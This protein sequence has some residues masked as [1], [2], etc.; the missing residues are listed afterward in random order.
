M[1]MFYLQ[2][3]HT[4]QQNL[5]RSPLLT[6][7]DE[8]FKGNLPAAN[9]LI[10]DR[11]HRHSR[12]LIL[13]ELRSLLKHLRPLTTFRQSRILC[14][15]VLVEILPIKSLVSKSSTDLGSRSHGSRKS[16]GQQ[17]PDAPRTASRDLIRAVCST[18]CSQLVSSRQ[19][20]H[21]VH[22]QSIYSL[23]K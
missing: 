19:R 14:K 18:L 17:P 15:D 3:N 2:S 20:E 5:E 6:T 11:L 23:L 22:A 21:L 13:Q 16:L 4:V 12:R 9:V 1:H 7:E 10:C 8:P